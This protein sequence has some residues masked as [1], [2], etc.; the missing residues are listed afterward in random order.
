MFARTVGLFRIKAQ[1]W[2]LNGSCAVAQPAP[3]IPALGSLDQDV[4][5][6]IGMVGKGCWINKVFTE[7]L[8]HSSPIGTSPGMP[9]ETTALKVPAMKGARYTKQYGFGLVYLPT[10]LQPHGQ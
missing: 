4:G 9:L 8:W 3:E 10:L 2:V 5:V 7:R 1:F 6:A